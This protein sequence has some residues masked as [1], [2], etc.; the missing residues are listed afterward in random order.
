M[1]NRDDLRPIQSAHL[2]TNQ[3]P[4]QEPG[5][6]PVPNMTDVK[7]SVQF[8]DVPSLQPNTKPT[9]VK[10]KGAKLPVMVPPK[11]EVSML[12]GCDI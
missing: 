6:A 9:Y 5:P 11:A 2:V 4:K 10:E 8:R 3:I 1:I 12:T 7:K